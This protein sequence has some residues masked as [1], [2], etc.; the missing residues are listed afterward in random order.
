L[1]NESKYWVARIKFEESMATLRQK[2]KNGAP[3]PEIAVA[4]Q[5]A[6]AAKYEAL[7]AAIVAGIVVSPSDPLHTE[8]PETLTAATS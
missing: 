2:L 8:H 5:T 1:D 7:G 4:R 3:S 6:I